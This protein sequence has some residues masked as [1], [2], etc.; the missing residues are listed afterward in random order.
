[1]VLLL[2]AVTA[3]AQESSELVVSTKSGKVSGIVQEG[4]MAWLGIPYAKVERLMPP[5]PVDKWKG[6]RKCDH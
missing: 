1:M 4:T 3:T 5:L 2:C 6:I